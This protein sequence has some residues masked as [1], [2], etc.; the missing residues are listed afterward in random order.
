ME[1]QYENIVQVEEERQQRREVPNNQLNYLNS[2]FL[3]RQK[4]LYDKNVLIKYLY[5]SSLNFLPVNPNCLGR[6]VYS[7]DVHALEIQMTST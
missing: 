1:I 3:C 5:Y 6:T 7:R 2:D 4:V